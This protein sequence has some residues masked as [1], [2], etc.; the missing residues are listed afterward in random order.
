MLDGSRVIWD[1]SP[2]DFSDRGCLST[3]MGQLKNR[4]FTELLLEELAYV[5]P[6]LEEWNRQLCHEN[7]Q[8]KIYSEFP[9]IDL[10]Q[11]FQNTP[12]LSGVLYSSRNCVV[13]ESLFQQNASCLKHLTDR[14]VHPVVQEKLSRWS[15]LTFSFPR[16]YQ[17]EG[18]YNSWGFVRVE[19]RRKGGNGAAVLL[20]ATTLDERVMTLMRRYRFEHLAD[21]YNEAWDGAIHDYIHHIALY[22]N[23]SFGVGKRSPLSLSNVHHLVDAWGEDML[24]TFNYEYWAHRTHRLITEKLFTPQHTLQRMDKLTTYL[25]EVGSFCELLCQNES[26][27]YV[28]KIST[29]LVCIYLWP[30][31]ILVHPF[32]PLFERVAEVVN[33]LQIVPIG[34]LQQEIL[35]RVQSVLQNPNLACGPKE[36]AL[37]ETVQRLGIEEKIQ[38]DTLDWFTL[39]RFQTDWVVQRGVYEGW[40]HNQPVL[41]QNRPVS[42]HQVTLQMLNVLQRTFPLFEQKLPEIEPYTLQGITTI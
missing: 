24:D 4:D 3:W 17:F 14:C 36:W 32:D 33:R 31:H 41:Y 35:F 25:Q 8:S 18:F 5:A 21:L 13:S 26:A 27:V 22:T 2:E 15:D 6:F 9:P 28:Q 38:N 29:Y 11:I 23:P 30:L 40:F 39:L 20:S 42:C 10:I 34:A 19:R 16:Q 12:A 1:V 7:G 37:R